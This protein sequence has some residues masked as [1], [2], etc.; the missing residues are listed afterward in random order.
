MS[1]DSISTSKRRRT[2]RSQRSRP[3]L[4]TSTAVEQSEDDVQDTPPVEAP[5][6]E[7]APAAPATPAPT[8]MVGRMRRLRSFI[9]TA[10]RGEQET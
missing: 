9:S 1:Q 2:A 3:V 7:V 5:A 10:G 4:V 8:S 6:P